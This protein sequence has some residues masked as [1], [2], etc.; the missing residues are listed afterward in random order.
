MW[1]LIGV[2]V[3]AAY[4]YSVVAT[5]FP[6]VIPME[7]K[8]GHGVA[9]YFEAA[10]MIVSLSLLGQI[11]E[12]STCQ[13]RRFTQSLT[14]TASQ[15]G[16]VGSKRSSGGS[17]YWH[18]QTRRYFTDFLGEQIPLDGVVVEGKTYVDEAM[19]TVNLCL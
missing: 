16:Q 13:D 7:A 2:G 14:Q 12:L 9:V 8:T 11:M 1:S 6:S 15:H 18:G 4:I 19:M 10:C 17:G 5:I 3:L